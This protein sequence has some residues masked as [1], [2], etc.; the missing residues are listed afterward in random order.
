[1]K[2]FGETHIDFIQKRKI[3]LVLSGIVLAVGIGSLIL[4][5][6]PR[7][8]LDFTGGVEVHLQFENNPSI[9]DIRSS[10][11]EVGLEKAIIQR[12]GNTKDNLVL[13]RYRVE[14]VAEDLAADIVKMREQSGGL[15]SLEQLKDFPAV[16]QIGFQNLVGTFTVDSDETEKVN[17]NTVSQEALAA[18]IRG[19]SHLKAAA[20]VE[21]ALRDRMDE[22]NPFEL[23][24]VDIIG[25]KVSQELQWSAFLA[26]IFALVGMLAYIA[27]RFE[28]RFAAGA[29]VALIHDVAICIG[30]LSLGN[31]EFSL[32]VIAALLTIIGYSLNDTIVI[33]DRIRENMK[34]LRKRKTALKDVIN[35]GINESLSRTVIT[36]LTTFVV[37]LAL[38]VWGGSVIHGFAF[39]LLIG[40][41]S[42]TYSSSFVATPVVYEWA[43]REKTTGR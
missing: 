8:G 35:L 1:M 38:F 6:G 11:R 28:L 42:G 22:D 36:S 34:T 19:V 16:S 27:W 21:R 43:K 29:V 39:T 20:D 18:R 5:G 2:L 4:K 17:L 33:Y 23:L 31:F 14:Q 13:I 25:P 37:V 7:L 15:D 40:V 26:V 24:S 32:P 30:A 12:Y 41:I 3:A 10:L 9:A